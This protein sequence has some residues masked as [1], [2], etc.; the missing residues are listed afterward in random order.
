MWFRL[1]GLLQSL[2]CLLLRSKITDLVFWMCCVE[3]LSLHFFLSVHGKTSVH[4]FCCLLNGLFRLTKEKKNIPCKQHTEMS[5]VFPCTEHDRTVMRGMLRNTSKISL[6]LDNVQKQLR[7]EYQ[8]CKILLTQNRMCF[9][10]FLSE[11]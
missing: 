1:N 10:W 11:R 3:G 8:D 6:L 4:S 9:S 5:V 7:M 2:Q